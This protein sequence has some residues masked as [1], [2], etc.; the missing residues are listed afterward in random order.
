MIADPL[1]DT[2]LLARLDIPEL[3][4]RLAADGP[5]EGDGALTADVNAYLEAWTHQIRAWQTAGVAPAEYQ[6]LDSLAAG[7]EA[8]Q[9]VI[10]FFVTLKKLPPIQPAGT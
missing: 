3:M 7:V 10:Q 2:G 8:A 5:G 4:E 9:R 1:Q 6:E